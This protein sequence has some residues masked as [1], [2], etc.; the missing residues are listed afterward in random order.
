MSTSWALAKELPR[1]GSAPAPAR[2]DLEKLIRETFAGQC[3]FF[4]EDLSQE[5]CR[6]ISCGSCW[7]SFPPFRCSLIYEFVIVF[8]QLPCFDRF[9]KNFE[10]CGTVDSLD[11]LRH[12]ASSS[13]PNIPQEEAKQTIAAKFELQCSAQHI[14]CPGHC[15]VLI[16]AGCCDLFSFLAL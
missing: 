9:S 1:G 4:W 2:A 12:I 8:F 6:H 14:Y 13:A 11:V 3:Q 5:S 15:S 7:L 10:I 16:E